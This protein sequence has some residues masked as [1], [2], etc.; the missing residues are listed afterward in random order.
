MM[1]LCHVIVGDEAFELSENVLRPYG[2]QKLPVKKRIFNYRLYRA[3]CYIECTFGILANK[4]RIFHRPLNVNV[5]LAVDIIKASCILHNFVRSRDGY[6]F[7]DPL[8]TPGL[9]EALQADTSSR[10]NSRSLC[11]REKFT[12]TESTRGTPMAI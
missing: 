5:D 7:E 1:T 8:T 4:W 2:G 6:N 11:I 9:V 3:R 12:G 10:E